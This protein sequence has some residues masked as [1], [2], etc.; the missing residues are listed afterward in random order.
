MLRRRKAFTLIELLVVIA[1]IAVLIGLLLPAVQKV[2][3]AAVR[4]EEFLVALLPCRFEG[5]DLERRFPKLWKKFSPPHRMIRIVAVPP[6]EAPPSIRE[7]WVGCILPLPAGEDSPRFGSKGRGVL[8]G[9]PQN[10]GAGYGVLA[11]EAIL[12]LERHDAAAARWWRDHAPR[13]LQPGKLL[14]FPATVCELLAEE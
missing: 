11:R 6:G 13:L 12:V 9:R 4:I 3:E 1:I 8:S 14:V 2:R 5:E 10:H 7:A